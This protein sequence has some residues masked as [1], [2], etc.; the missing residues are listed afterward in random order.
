MLSN[1]LFGLA[2]RRSRPRPLSVAA[3]SSSACRGS[4]PAAHLVVA[5]RGET[6]HCR[7]VGRADMNFSLKLGYR[8]PLADAHSG[9]C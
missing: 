2:C 9:L 3:R 4:A 6:Y 7:C 5:H 1:K 8:R